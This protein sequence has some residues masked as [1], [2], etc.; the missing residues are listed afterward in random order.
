M[1]L[2]RASLGLEVSEQPAGTRSSRAVWL[3]WSCKLGRSVDAGMCSGEPGGED[4]MGRMQLL[5]EG[6]GCGLVAHGGLRL[7]RA[8]WERAPGNS[9]NPEKRT[10]PG[11]SW[12]T[13]SQPWGPAPTYLPWT[14]DLHCFL[15]WGLSG[16][17]EYPQILLS[18]SSWSQNFP[19]EE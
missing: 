10:L 12:R 1:L 3:R 7:V 11:W 13:L 6:G 5:G 19:V 14:L 15:F 17:S 9:E 16:H 4:A 2:P 8:L 18:S